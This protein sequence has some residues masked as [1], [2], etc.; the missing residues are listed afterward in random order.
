MG[1]PVEPLIHPSFFHDREAAERCRA[2]LAD[3]GYRVSPIEAT[4]EGDAWGA[5]KLRAARVVDPEEFESE[6]ERVGTIISRFGGYQ[7]GSYWAVEPTGV[8]G[9]DDIPPAGSAGPS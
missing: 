2:E 7:D 9:W 1:E 3:A 6:Y 8:E 5:W 4:E